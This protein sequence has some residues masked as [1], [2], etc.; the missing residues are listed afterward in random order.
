MLILQLI[1]AGTAIG[2]YAVMAWELAD[3]AIRS[4]LTLDAF[5]ARPD[6]YIEDMQFRVTGALCIGAGAGVWLGIG[7]RHF[8]LLRVM[9]VF[10]GAIALVL[11]A[12]HALDAFDR[13]VWSLSH[14]TLHPP[15]GPVG[16]YYPQL[17]AAGLMLIPTLFGVALAGGVQKLA[18]ALSGRNFRAQVA[19]ARRKRY[20][21]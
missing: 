19:R 2:L 4:G 5:M 18:Q 21:R 12:S 7:F 20:A 13:L 10:V 9:T 11:G 3:F 8:S 15:R 6:S 14:F 17:A 16:R 1:A